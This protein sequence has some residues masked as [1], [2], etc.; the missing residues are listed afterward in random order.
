MGIFDRMLGR[1]ERA[2]SFQTIWGAGGDLELGS[3]S[4]TI[5]NSDTAFKIN[6][7]FSAVSLISDTISTLP[8]DAYIRRDGARF[9]FRPR[10]EW[11][12]KPDVDTTKEAFYGSVIVSLLLDGNAF[13]RVFSNSRG[14]VTNLVVLNPTKV[15]IKRNGIGR[16]SFRLRAKRSCF[17]QKKSCLSQM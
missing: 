7:V 9:A 13:I 12:T 16:V 17:Q 6:A 14:Q 10:P 5:I 4:A 3:Q 8:V 1:E 11:V 15:E 2:V